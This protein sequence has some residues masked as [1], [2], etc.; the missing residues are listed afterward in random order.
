M[1]LIRKGPPR[2]CPL[3]S[4]ERQTH[5]LCR[6][7]L[8]HLIPFARR[9]IFGPNSASTCSTVR[10]VPIVMCF[11]NGHGVVTSMLSFSSMTTDEALAAFFKA[12]HHSQPHIPCLVAAA[13][14]E[15]TSNAHRGFTHGILLHFDHDPQEAKAHPKYQEMFAKARR[16][17]D[18]VIIFELPETLSVTF[19]DPVSWLA[20]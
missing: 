7:V 16:R 11:C 3:R 6:L 19:P 13:T 12:V 10:T 20:W 9:A 17:C 8:C 2:G 15:N 14:G 1:S 5:R 4:T 18:Q